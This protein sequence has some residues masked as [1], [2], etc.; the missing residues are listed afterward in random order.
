MWVKGRKG[1]KHIAMCIPLQLSFMFCTCTPKPKHNKKFK[2]Y[3]K[4]EIKIQIL[5]KHLFKKLVKFKSCTFLKRQHLL[6]VSCLS[7]NAIC[8]SR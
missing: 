3:I 1:A 2:N 7:V 5:V 8:V 4:K 6:E